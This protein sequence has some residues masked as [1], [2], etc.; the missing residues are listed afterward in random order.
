MLFLNPQSNAG[1]EYEEITIRIGQRIKFY[2]QH[3]L[4]S[5]G[6]VIEADIV[7]ETVTLLCGEIIQYT[8]TVHIADLIEG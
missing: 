1:E 7:D 3:G 4:I 2:D 8:E 6:K 5:N